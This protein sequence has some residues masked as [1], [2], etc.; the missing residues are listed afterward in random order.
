MR[1]A[2]FNLHLAAPPSVF[3]L[4]CDDATEKV[5]YNHDSGTTRERNDTDTDPRRSKEMN[6]FMT[7]EKCWQRALMG[8]FFYL[9][10]V[11]RNVPCHRQEQ[12][13]QGS[14][15]VCYYA[16][17]HFWADLYSSRATHSFR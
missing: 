15:Q 1:G 2:F 13:R 7:F 16:W 11:Y 8:F 5:R 6:G 4:L 10:A 9:G 3:L 12:R 17:S 14:A